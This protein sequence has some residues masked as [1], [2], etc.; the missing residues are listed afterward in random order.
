MGIL[1]R[2]EPNLK[3]GTFNL[4]W[5]VGGTINMDYAYIWCVRLRPCCMT[6]HSKVSMCQ[7]VISAMYGNAL[8]DKA[9]ITHWRTDWQSGDDRARFVR[10]IRHAAWPRLYSPFMSTIILFVLNF[11]CTYSLISLPYL[12]PYRFQID[13]QFDRKWGPIS[14][15]VDLTSI[16]R[17]VNQLPNTYAIQQYVNEEN[18]I[19]NKISHVE[20]K[21]WV[22][23]YII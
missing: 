22:A 16:V 10:M 13:F 1:C 11:F 17:Y 23:T 19:F 5:H 21:Y 7:C 4:G 2:E 3:Y 8:T 14:R 6:D 20:F 15:D 18:N 12:L 9:E